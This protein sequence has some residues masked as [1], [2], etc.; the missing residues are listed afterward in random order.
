M[1]FFKTLSR[2]MTRA[3][4][5]TTKKIWFSTVEDLLQSKNVRLQE[6]LRFGGGFSPAWPDHGRALAPAPEDG[7][8]GSR[9]RARRLP[10]GKPIRGTSRGDCTDAAGPFPRGGVYRLG[11]SGA[12]EIS[13]KD[14]ER[15]SLARDCRRGVRW[16]WRR[17][18]G[19][20]GTWRRWARWFRVRWGRRGRRGGIARR[21]GRRGRW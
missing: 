1:C 15:V 10:A 20:R 19:S 12:K 16:S 13:S 5:P 4:P 18:R 14:F 3:A 7:L 2:T 11:S 17:G 9:T 8:I 21:R 6:P